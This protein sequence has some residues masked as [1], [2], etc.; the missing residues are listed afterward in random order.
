MKS[1]K[2]EGGTLEKWQLHTLS[3]SV[4]K[5]KEL[6]QDIQTDK[7]YV[8]T[9]VIA[10]DPTGRWQPGHHFRSSLVVAM[11]LDKGIVETQNT[12]YYVKGPGNN[13]IVPELGDAVTGLFY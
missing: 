4:E 13:D 11:D 9:G 8:L 5:A 2:K 12:I 7:C 1:E 3:V 6:G 10:E